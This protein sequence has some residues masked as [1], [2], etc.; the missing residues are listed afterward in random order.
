MFI[1]EYSTRKQFGYVGSHFLRSSRS[2]RVLCL[3]RARGFQSFEGSL[4]SL[5]HGRFESY[6]YHVS[7]SRT[8]WRWMVLAM[9]LPFHTATVTH[10]L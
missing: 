10:I 9:D 7:L 8:R 1:D 5:K 2:L 6:L 3:L 4:Q